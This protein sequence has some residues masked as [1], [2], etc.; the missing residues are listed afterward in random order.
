MLYNVQWMYTKA[1]III[2]SRS[3]SFKRP[4]FSVDVS[5]CLSMCLSVCLC[6]TLM[7]SISENKRFRGFVPNRKPTSKRKLPIIGTVAVRWRQVGRLNLN[8]A[9]ANTLTDFWHCIL[10]VRTFPKDISSSISM[11]C[12]DDIIVSWYHVHKH[13]HTRIQTTQ[14][15]S[16]PHIENV[17][18]DK[19]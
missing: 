18:N 19:I 15:A 10:H 13:T 17:D 9:R 12:D 16:R 5:V 6:A 4:L 7:L 3:A 8:S 14:A 1:Q 2:G 11:A